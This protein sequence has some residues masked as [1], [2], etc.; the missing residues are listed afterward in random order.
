MAHYLV[1]KK[2][3]VRHANAISG[4]FVHGFPAMTAFT[5]FMWALERKWHEHNPDRH[6][7]RF[8]KIG[9]IAHDYREHIL[10]D[11]GSPS[12]FCKKSPP[13]IDKIAEGR[14]KNASFNIA[15]YLDMT[16]SLVIEIERSDTSV[17]DSSIFGDADID[18][19]TR[20]IE[21]MRIAGG[22]IDKIDRKSRLPAYLEADDNDPSVLVK[23]LMS[24]GYGNVIIARPDLLE[25]RRKQLTD[26]WKIIA[27]ANNGLP[28]TCKVTTR[29]DLL[30]G[31]ISLAPEDDESVR[32][33][34]PEN[35]MFSA[36]PS[37]IDVMLSFF[38]FIQEEG[39]AYLD[40][41]DEKRIKN[42]AS[43]IKATLLDQD[44]KKNAAASLAANKAYRDLLM[45]VPYLPPE[46][47]EILMTR[48][49][50][51]IVPVVVGYVSIGEELPPE[52]AEARDGITNVVPSETVVSLCEWVSI[53]R[54]L[55][56][57]ISEMM[58]NPKTM[59]NDAGEKIAFTCENGKLPLP[60]KLKSCDF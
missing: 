60:A 54:A 45:E 33:V 51:W 13:E 23:E 39:S 17:P 31:D 46:A 34:L 58:W 48:P 21:R 15:G 59:H 41:E 28:V 36:S 24:L 26:A 7:V 32:Q 38:F 12:F 14:V 25:V 27:E 5:G 1:L 50:G 10:D 2:L 37:D 20:I 4:Q 40:K 49:K 57:A 22:K 47:R 30:Q 53:R 3:S 56:G 35:S 42:D 11:N 9:V 55:S 43:A 52:I 8:A 18:L 16:V 44:I 6:Y 29:A 19:L